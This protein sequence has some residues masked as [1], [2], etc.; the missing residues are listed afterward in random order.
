M[1]IC[2]SR[3]DP[4]TPP[5]SA[6]M[7]TP[8]S[9]WV[10]SVI[11]DAAAVQWVLVLDRVKCSLNVLVTYHPAKSSPDL[12][13]RLASLLKCLLLG[14]QLVSHEPPDNL[15]EHVLMFGLSSTHAWHPTTQNHLLFCEDAPGTC[16]SQS[17]HLRWRRSYCCL[18]LEKDGFTW[19]LKNTKTCSM[20]DW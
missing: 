19:M 17:T 16:I 13:A 1:T 2:S 8:S 6:G 10:E 5:T 12:S 11:V 3:K 9:P 18:L 20:V 4:P 14:R 7:F 15:S